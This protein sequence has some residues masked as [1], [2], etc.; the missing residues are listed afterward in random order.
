[1]RQSLKALYWRFGL[2]GL[3]SYLIGWSMNLLAYSVN[4]RGRMPEVNLDGTFDVIPRLA[5]FADRWYYDSPI[6][7]LRRTYSI[8]D[9]LIGLGLILLAISLAL[10]AVIVKRRILVQKEKPSPF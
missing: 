2:V 7:F 1:M 5:I 9:V 8:G 4:G 6:Y 10:F 3:T